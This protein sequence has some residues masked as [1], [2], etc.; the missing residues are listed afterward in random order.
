MRRMLLTLV[1]L[2]AIGCGGVQTAM[3]HGYGHG[4]GHGYHGGAPY[5]AGYASYGRGGCGPSFGYGAGYGGGYG[6]SANYAQPGY[7]Y[8]QPGYGYAQPGYQV[9]YPQAGFGVAGRNFSLWFQQ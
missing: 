6:Y 7:G 3:A 9:A 4:Y 2:A 5:R 8:A 1:S